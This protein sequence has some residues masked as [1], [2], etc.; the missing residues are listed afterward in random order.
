VKLTA[1]LPNP[2]TGFTGIVDGGIEFPVLERPG[3]Q[4]HAVGRK[5]DRV[6]RVAMP[7]EAIDES[8]N[9]D[10]PD[11]HDGVQRPRSNEACI[12][13]DSH[14]CDARVDIGIIVDRVDL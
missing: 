4:A 10:V 14:A 11:A 6:D 3:H 1:L 9:R 12:G 7:A 13:G 8:A 5:R 2:L